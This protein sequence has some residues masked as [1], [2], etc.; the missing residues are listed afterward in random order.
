[1]NRSVIK[2]GAYE[3]PTVLRRRTG[4]IKETE[5]M[6]IRLPVVDLQSLR[7]DGTLSHFFFLPPSAHPLPD[8]DF[9]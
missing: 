4:A 9:A 2:F 1:M 6:V 8:L 3:A 5:S 7:G